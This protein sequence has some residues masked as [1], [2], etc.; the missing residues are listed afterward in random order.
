MINIIDK[1]SKVPLYYQL[2]EMI[3]HD[4]EYNY[5]DDERLSSEREICEQY[6]LS[7][8]TVRQA[9]L[10]LERQGY[11]YRIHGKGTFVSPRKINQNLLNF[12]S[13]SKE[14]KK[15]GRVPSSKVISFEC[16]GCEAFLAEKLKLQPGDEIYRF[17][18]I[19]LADGEPMMVDIS[20]VPVKRFPGLTK[21]ELLCDAM[22]DIFI[23]QFGVEINYAEEKFQAVST[24]KQIAEYLH[25][26]CSLPSLK[27]ERFT[28]EKSKIIEYTITYARGDQFIYSIRLE[29]NDSDTV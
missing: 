9:L 3:R 1:S 26:D 21:E 13:F 20:H 29:K 18:R 12:Y 19:R 2:I 6:C 14:M 16:L 10:E 24:D 17:V 11:I 25:M 27:I 15:I 4:I 8:S 22:Y 7:R 23:R 28:Y 5:H